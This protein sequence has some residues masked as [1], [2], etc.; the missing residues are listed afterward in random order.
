MKIEDKRCKRLVN[1]G[2]AGYGSAF[3][4]GNTLFLKVSPV[5]GKYQDTYNAVSLDGD[6]ITY[7]KDEDLVGEVECKVVVGEEL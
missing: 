7:F 6:Y 4:S 1:F 2:D 5:E 3:F